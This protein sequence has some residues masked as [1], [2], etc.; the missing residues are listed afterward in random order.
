[1]T[2]TNLTL[3]M[4]FKTDEGKTTTISLRN[5]DS[6]IE[7]AQVKSVMQ[8]VADSRLFTSTAGTA[9]TPH[10][11]QIVEKTNTEFDLA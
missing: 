11:A 2:K 4:A 1:M 9:I 3:V 6:T 8:V 5:I 10:S 7:S